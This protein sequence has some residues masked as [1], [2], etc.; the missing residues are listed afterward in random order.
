MFQ[1]IKFTKVNKLIVIFFL[2]IFATNSNKVYGI[3]EVDFIE[4]TPSK[5]EYSSNGGDT[6]LLK[7]DENMYYIDIDNT[8]LKDGYYT[9]YM[10]ENVSENWS[11]YE[12]LKFKVE[13]KAHSSI[14][15]NFNIRTNE[16]KILTVPD[17]KN[18]LIKNSGEEQIQAINP[19]YG[20]LELSE[21]FNGEI[22]I[23]FNS[24]SENDKESSDF[25]AV[26]NIESWGIIL[27]AAEN[28]KKS[29]VIGD[30]RLIKRG[31]NLKK[32]FESNLIIEGDKEVQIPVLG[33]G[34]SNYKI[35]DES[36]NEDISEKGTNVRFKLKE[37]VD[38]VKIS[39]NGRLTVYPDAEPQEIEIEATIDDTLVRNIK[40][41]LFESWTLKAK[42]V[43]G[44][45]K[46]I[47]KESEVNKIVD[48]KKISYINN[49]IFM[50][51][52][53]L[54]ST[55]VFGVGLYLKWKKDERNIN[56]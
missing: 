36:N 9:T 13:D 1:L 7:K 14:R 49:S 23:P 34:I 37:N 4:Y 28:E 54:I 43:D 18:V 8:E 55:L 50:V 52:V 47:P 44:T 35:N 25:I 32:Y 31:S 15:I 22:Y 24:F 29:L 53:I 40:I 56:P 10:Y 30:F 2:L 39:E 51:Y 27:T 20:T 11:D 42:E 48:N 17:S 26:S 12:G 33:E 38:G 3:D 19:E 16:G 46:S 5:I 21:D 45:S 41:Q 6:T